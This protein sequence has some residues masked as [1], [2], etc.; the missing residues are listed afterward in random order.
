MGMGAS[1]VRV[2]KCPVQ[3]KEAVGP[4]PTAPGYPEGSEYDVA[5]VMEVVTVKDLREFAAQNPAA[6]VSVMLG[7]E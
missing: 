2:R 7:D 4:G 6:T 3:E 1:K 5:E